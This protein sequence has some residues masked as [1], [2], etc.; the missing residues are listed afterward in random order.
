M[1]QQNP[2]LAPQA[3]SPAPAPLGS[4]MA[5]QPQIAQ[6]GAPTAQVDNFGDL[7]PDQLQRLAEAHGI[8]YKEAATM[9]RMKRAEALAGTPGAEGRH[10]GNVFVAANP[11]E[12]LGAAGM[13][14]LG[15]RGMREATDE[16]SGLGDRYANSALA[17]YQMMGGRGLGF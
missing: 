5:D 17:G 8:S 14:A 1:Y 15:L 3:P 16:L 11:M 7:D 10:Q 2:S 4:Q 9:L 12:V 13:R 6:A